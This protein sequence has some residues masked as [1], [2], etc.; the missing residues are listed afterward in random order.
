MAEVSCPFCNRKVN[1][2]NGFSKCTSC[3]LVVNDHWRADSYDDGYFAESYREQYGRSYE[4]DFDVIYSLSLHRLTV[5]DSLVKK[6]NVKKDLLDI[7][8]AYGF[9]LKAAY[10]K[11]YSC[12]GIEISPHAAKYA[13]SRFPFEVTT[14]S[15]EKASLKTY[16]II[17]FWYVIEH[18][19][20]IK[21]NLD[22]ALS[23]VSPNGIIAFSIPS[24]FGPSYFFHRS[25]W[26]REHPADHR[27][28]FSPKGLR[29]ILKEAGYSNVI[30][31][32]ASYHPERVISS[33]SYIYPLFSA[34]YKLFAD[35]TGFGDTIEIFAVNRGRFFGPNSISSALFRGKKC[36]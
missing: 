33:R 36:E 11:G 26:E 22:R 2:E 7:G 9:F 20:E 32:P 31:R 4:D 3:A 25:Q 24:W 6:Y 30:I 23:I 21:K 17:T 8:C 35:C 12:S 5:I 13:S 14:V 34:F 18:F 16:P 10:D 28:D 29:K 19:Y 1:T 15:F 27:V